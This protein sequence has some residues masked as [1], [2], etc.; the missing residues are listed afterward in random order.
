MLLGL[1]LSAAGYFVCQH[2]R[3]AVSL[4]ERK[5]TERKRA[6]ECL[7]AASISQAKAQADQAKVNADMKAL[8]GA[9]E[10]ARKKGLSEAELLAAEKKALESE[11]P[12][13]TLP[14]QV[15]VT[16]DEC[17]DL[18]ASF[19]SESNWILAFAPIIWLYGFLGGFGV[20]LFY[21][22]VRFAVKG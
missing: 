16:P 9:T 19:V 11:P 1:L 7:A 4:Q 18:S 12:L 21:R 13:P 2:R 17:I 6:A 22:L 20:W 5:E 10:L 15:F 3:E 8:S 14:A